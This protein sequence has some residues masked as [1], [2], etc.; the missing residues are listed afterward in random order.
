MEQTTLGQRVTTLERRVSKIELLLDLSDEGSG[1]RFPAEAEDRVALP[2]PAQETPLLS[3]LKELRWKNAASEERAKAEEPARAAHLPPPL[4]MSFAP[5]VEMDP[6]T[7]TGEVPEEVATPVDVVPTEAASEPPVVPYVSIEPAKPA[8]QS[9][10]ERTIGLK[11]AGWVGAVV[12][13]IGAALGVKFAYDQ[14]WMGH[15]PPLA[16]LSMII[17]AGLALIGAGEWVYRRVNIFPAASLFGAGIATLFIASY[18]G[19]AYY[20]LYAPGTAFVLMAASTILGAAVA[21]RGNLVSIAVLSLIGG[22]LAPILLTTNH[23]HLVP[24]LTY[25]LMLQEIALVLAF[26]GGNRKWWTLRGFSFAT[27]AAWMCVV[28]MGRSF[29]YSPADAPLWFSLIFAAGYQLELI[30]ST[31]RWQ[32]NEN[33]SPNEAGIGVPFSILVTAGLSASVLVLFR[34]A[35]PEV[36]ATWI[37]GIAAA[38]AAAGMLLRRVRGREG[39]LAMLAVGYG[40]QAAGLLIVAVPVALSGTWIVIGWAVLAAAF[41]AAGRM[42]NLRTSRVAALAS[43]ALAVAQLAS[44]A[45]LPEGH[46]QAYAIWLTLF[47]QPIYAY[48]ILAAILAIVGQAIAWTTHAALP[49]GA[50]DNDLGQWKRAAWLTSVAAS[51]VWIAAAWASLPPV[52]ATAALLLYAWL[53]AGAD[54]TTRRLSFAFQSVAVVGIAA[55]KWAVIDTISAANAPHWTSIRPLLNPLMGVGV[56]AALSVAGIP[57]LRR[58]SLRQALEANNAS[59]DE[60]SFIVTLSG[61]V[62]G[63]LTIGFSVE[64]ARVVGA[65]A[66]AHKALAWTPAQLEHLSWT[67]LWTLAVSG[68]AWIAAKA[69][70]SNAP[71]VSPEAA[72]YW[73]LP[74]ALAAKY[75][76]V[77][78]LLFR[79]DA[80]PCS[81]AAVLNLQVFAGVFVAAAILGV[82]LL[83]R[84]RAN[85]HEHGLVS[86][87][88]RIP[89][90]VFALSLG[91]ILWAGTFE[92][93]RLVPYVRGAA[94][95]HPGQLTQMLWTMWWV[96]GVITFAAI[97]PWLDGSRWQQGAARR[98]A[99]SIL[100]CLAGKYLLID[101]LAFRLFEGSA[102]APVLLNVQAALGAIVIGAMAYVRLMPNAQPED[103]RLQRVAGFLA[104]LAALWLGSIEIDRFFESPRTARLFADPL[105]AKQVALSVYWSVFAVLSVV[106]GF[107][108]R[109]P[110]VRYFG[111]GL[112]AVTLLKVVI[113]DLHDVGTGYRILSF[114]GL[115]LLLLGTSVLYG[116]L[117]PRLLADERAQ[118]DPERLPLSS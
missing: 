101:T 56:L 74:A 53:L 79:L 48:A 26:L 109:A 59:L 33:A 20:N 110:A 9:A 40:I 88:A 17:A 15:V 107:R 112:F 19:H 66:A 64:I 90:D 76:L 45:T 55:A 16:R 18:A 105:L 77:D 89:A 58:K 72:H 39:S 108:V 31:L 83:T 117:G 52:G 12:L 73:W 93:E 96:V 81:P 70:R 38:C 46:G 102:A 43:W 65:A 51:G 69:R 100:I 42:L 63:L 78:T 36:R 3:R 13:V 68:F 8:Q 60:A 4:P 94:G 80:Q 25:L 22:N 27:T 47:G 7:V 106:A 37:I 50:A 1:E 6:T 91:V 113:V 111:L 2:P 41:A 21:P 115:G 82:E 29:S 67:M 75:I 98:V 116:K 62:I 61:V 114:M 11:W 104:V 71:D 5:V 97:A 35:S 10:L 103:R 99:A 14:G 24:F 95:W 118:N 34:D 57:L 92:I 86:W 54:I 44:W 87:L 84:P 85:G 30:A 23:P 28:L 32:S 49:A